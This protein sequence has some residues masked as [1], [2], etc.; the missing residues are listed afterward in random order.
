MPIAFR[1]AGAG[2][3]AAT[4]GPHRDIVNCWDTIV[5][6]VSYA[7]EEARWE[8]W[9]A[10]ILAT[11]GATEQDLVDAAAVYL[12]HMIKTADPEVK[13]IE[14]ALVSSGWADLKPSARLVFMYSL[15]LTASRWYFTLIRDANVVGAVL[16]KNAAEIR[17]AIR[18]MAQK[19]ARKESADGVRSE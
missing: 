1:P 4:Y 5:E 12:E 6:Q 10:Q 13:S 17:Q 14:E 2:V 18:M 3:D 15:G 19:Y 11:D 9:F 8:P 7:I 16:P